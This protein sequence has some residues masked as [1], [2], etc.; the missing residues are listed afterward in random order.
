MFRE[1][2]PDYYQRLLRE[3]SSR[4]GE[5]VDLFVEER[6]DLLLDVDGA[7]GPSP[8]RWLHD[9]GFAVRLTG[10][11][12]SIHRCASP[13][14]EPRIRE[15]FRSLASEFGVEPFFRKPSRRLGSLESSPVP[16]AEELAGLEEEARTI[17]ARLATLAARDRAGLR[18]A[19]I[20]LCR[21]RRGILARERAWQRWARSELHLS[22]RVARAGKVASVVAGAVR[23]DA[24]LD[25]Y[26]RRAL[27]AA[28][29]EDEPRHPPS[30]TPVTALFGEGTA[31]S[32]FHELV[33]HMLEADALA[34]GLSPLV[35]VLGAT[36]APPTVT[37]WDDPDRPDLPGGLPV[38][39]EGNPC[40]RQPLLDRGRIGVPLGDV[41]HADFGPPGRARR[42]SWIDPPLPRITNLVVEAGQADLETMLRTVSRGIFVTSL[43]GGSV[44]PASGRFALRVTSGRWI[45]RGELGPPCPPV[46]LA[47]DLFNTLEMI[48]PEIGEDLAVDYGTTICSRRGQSVPVGGLAPLVAVPGLVTGPAEN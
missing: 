34:E 42:A 22:L 10:A 41:Y 29:P 16:A 33:G 43:G 48:R 19:R 25:A 36:V 17:A 38:D 28:L 47:G 3:L 11:G 31:A 23:Y 44:D 14:S 21:R 6:S 9:S 45:R 30:R 39:D 18:S 13:A 27:A 2:D 4:P 35:Q 5:R 24:G 1:L 26:L 7:E 46:W 40:T 15:I 12:G 20:S 32:F 37:V 8:P